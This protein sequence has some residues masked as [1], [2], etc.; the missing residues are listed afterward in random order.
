MT[1]N[2]SARR[3]KEERLWRDR[4]IVRLLRLRPHALRFSPREIRSPD[5]KIAPFPPREA[6]LAGLKTL[7]VFDLP[8]ETSKARKGF[9]PLALFFG[10]F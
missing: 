10:F 4:R 6:A 3:A 8:P 2:M 9:G 5:A 1:Q 7:W